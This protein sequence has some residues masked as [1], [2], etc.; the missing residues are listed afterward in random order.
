GE[1]TLLKPGKTLSAELLAY[2]RAGR[3]IWGEVEDIPTPI[4]QK[5][6]WK[7]ATETVR[8]GRRLLEEINGFI[9]KYRDYSL[10]KK[11]VID[12]PLL[13]RL[14]MFFHSLTLSLPPAE[15][16]ERFLSYLREN[17]DMEAEIAYAE[18]LALFLSEQFQ[19]LNKYWLY[20]TNP[21][22][23]LSPDL[24]EKREVLVFLIEEFLRG[25]SDEFTDLQEKWE[26]FFEE[27]IGAYREKHELYYRAAIF[28]ARRNVEELPEARALRRIAGQVGSVTF[29]GEWW[30]LKRELDRL[31]EVCRQDLSSELFLN[32][33]CGCGFTID[34]AAPELAVDFTAACRAGLRKFLLAL[35]T[36]ENRE[37]LDS[38][39]LSLH[40]GGQGDLATRCTSLLN[41][42]AEKANVSLLLPLLTDEVLTAIEKALKGRWTVRELELADFI[43]K[44]KGRRFRQEELKRLFLQWIGDDQDCIIHLR[45]EED[46]ATLE[47]KEGFGRYGTQG[48]AIFR[49]LMAQ[50]RG[51][52]S[53]EELEDRLQEEEGFPA[54]HALR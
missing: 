13:S 38:F 20:L 5:L 36:T 48:E 37:R 16:L 51:V 9:N 34:S 31:P 40:D 46:A 1:I 19:P 26:A 43:G 18:R 7:E 21:A 24:R 47:L 8:R 42:N 4:T 49:A 27:Y 12:G 54:L 10:L 11:A 52:R 3:F 32:P 22:L 39:L 25:R 45:G 29:P 44:V 33:V 17:P 14:G 50:E 15:G 53:Y 2:I 35:K 6:M 30:E 28:A 23:K 41:L